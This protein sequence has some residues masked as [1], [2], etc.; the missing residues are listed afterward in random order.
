[1]PGT[2]WPSIAGNQMLTYDDVMLAK[3]DGYLRTIGPVPLG[4]AGNELV[5]AALWVTFVQNSIDI[6]DE[7]EIVYKDAVQT[8]GGI[9]DFGLG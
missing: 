5:S 4:V 7:N 8:S 2:P 3:N 6:R 9:G 1:M